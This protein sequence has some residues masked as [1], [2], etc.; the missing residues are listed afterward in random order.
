MTRSG[1]GSSIKAVAALAGVSIAT[2]SRV[3]N[4]VAN[5]ASAETTARVRS[6][7]AALDYRPASA[8]RALRQRTSRLVAVLAANLAN[9]AMA[10]IAASAEIA[11]RKRGLVMVLC[12]THDRPALQD[13]YLKEMQAQQARAIVLLAAVESPMLAAMRGGPTPIVFVNRRDPAGSAGLHVGIDNAAAGREVAVHCLDAGARTIAIIHGSLASSATSERVRAVREALAARGVPHASV[14]VETAEDDDH[15]AI[16]YRSA[17]RLLERSSPVDA[18]ICTSDLIA[19][20]A[21]RR[22][23]EDGG[24]P[25]RLVGFDDSP[26]NDWIAP[27]L[28]SVRI[29]YENYGEAIVSLLAADDRAP[30]A[31]IVPYR[32]MVRDGPSRNRGR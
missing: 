16:G 1:A 4:G 21:H 7:V 5:K 10:A 30:A 3:V 2:V 31:R 28:T 32:L 17:K 26:L 6:A 18:V 13:E 15:L 24:A 23:V 12:D 27:W 25:P 8:G 22:Y 29:P 9:P 14:V 19:F 20:G 11:L